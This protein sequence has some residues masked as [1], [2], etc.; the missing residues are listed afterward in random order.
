M[1]EE[2]KKL[3]AQIAELQK[4]LQQVK[5]TTPVKNDKKKKSPKKKV[6]ESIEDFENDNDTDKSCSLDNLIDEDIVIKKKKKESPKKK[7]IESIEDVEL[8]IEDNV[9]DEFTLNF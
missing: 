3:K 5:E 2:N 7:V 8:N 9:L 6:A 1:L 4:Q